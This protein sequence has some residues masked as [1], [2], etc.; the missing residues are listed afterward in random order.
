MDYLPWVVVAGLSAVLV[1]LRKS[2]DHS[3]REIALANF[4]V[5]LMLDGAT[6]EQQRRDFER[7]V[8]KL[9]VRSKRNLYLIVRLHLSDIATQ[10]G[11]GTGTAN[12]Q[13]TWNLN[14]ATKNS[15]E[16]NDMGPE[17]QLQSAINT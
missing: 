8:K 5:L 16:T 2:S 7:L 6:Y 13:K 1:L 3:N 4:L 14:Q 12:S 9:K 10:M 15:I 11:W 17:S